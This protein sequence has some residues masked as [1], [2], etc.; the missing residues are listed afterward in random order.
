MTLA[1]L[2]K[3]KTPWRQQ[4]RRVR[5]QLIPV[6]TMAGTLFLTGWL[7][8]QHVRAVS[9]LGEAQIIETLV[10]SP[11]VGLLTAL[12]GPEPA[13]FDLVEKDQV[14]AMLDDR[15]L[16]A[17]LAVLQSELAHLKSELA[18]KEEEL[19]V[20]DAERRLE[21]TREANRLAL[22]LEQSR[23]RMLELRTQVDADRIELQRLNVLYEQVKQTGSAGSRTEL[24]NAQLS[25]DV[26]QERLNGTLRALQAAEEQVE[27]LNKRMSELNSM[28]G[29]TDVNRIL[30]PITALMAVQ[31]ERLKEID[32][33]IQALT[34]KAPVSGRIS[35]IYK[36]RGEVVQAGDPILKIVNERGEKVLSYLRQD[37]PIRLSPQM[38]VEVRSRLG[39]RAVQG[40][41][42][43]IGPQVE[44]IPPHQLRDQKLPEWGIPILISMPPGIHLKPGELVDVTLRPTELT[45]E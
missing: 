45:A 23:L 8:R 10:A 13:V 15:Q 17:T 34:I 25:R 32:V 31:A 42:E 1:D 18:A 26:V 37:Q 40:V 11:V 35:A 41:I 9:T 44:P 33:Q 3:I 12:P 22:Q 39:G 24:I 4:W 20:A 2:P 14:V 29:R 5:Y 6:L 27:G 7:W 28:A 16:R 21:E 19:R 43:K 30:E 36:R 38:P